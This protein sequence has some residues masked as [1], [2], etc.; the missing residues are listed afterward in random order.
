MTIKIWFGVFDPV[1]LR[2]YYA[3]ENKRTQNAQKQ[4]FRPPRDHQTG[5]GDRRM[6]IKI[7]F[8]V[9]SPIWLRS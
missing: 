2:S 1:W 4:P 9:F 5:Y 8:G 7:W 3:L 6:T